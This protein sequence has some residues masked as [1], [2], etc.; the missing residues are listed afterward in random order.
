MRLVSNE[1]ENKS[2]LNLGLGEILGQPT[3]KSAET[4]HND[5]AQN[6]TAATSFSVDATT[7]PDNQSVDSQAESVDEYTALAQSKRWSELAAMA[8]KHNTLE[9][10]LWWAIAQ[11]ELAQMP[12]SIISAPLE[13]SLR[14]IA[15]LHTVP[16]KL[17]DLST[18]VAIKISQALIERGELN[19][20][21]ALLESGR[22]FSTRLDAKFR[23]SAAKELNQLAKLPAR[24]L[25]KQKIARKKY[26]E[27][28]VETI[29]V[30]TAIST[31]SLAVKVDE[32]RQIKRPSSAKVVLYGV[33]LISLLT[34]SSLYYFGAFRSLS[35]DPEGGTF[36]QALTSSDLPAP[37]LKLLPVQR[38]SSTSMLEAVLIEDEQRHGTEANN[39]QS[40]QQNRV[41]VE[42]QLV[43][44]DRPNLPT[45]QSI[46]A[47]PVAPQLP[48]SPVVREKID[49]SGP[50]EPREIREAESRPRNGENRSDRADE[51][52]EKPRDQRDSGSNFSGNTQRYRVLVRTEVHAIPSF[53][54][55]VL[56]RL[57][58]GDPVAVEER[59]G[60]WF[61]IR[62][63]NGK[64]GYIAA[65]DVEPE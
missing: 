16:Q 22:S 53:N 44:N 7:T 17:V 35:L 8:E 6:S 20:A 62:G 37:T 43:I 25:D 14:E 13:Q 18:D 58:R 59:E 54:S 51:L 63:Q 33:L 32:T 24:E 1:R 65:Q 64:S 31:T 28:F 49:T 38:S 21:T 45:N 2:T 39:S 12:L 10:R 55:S 60:L 3:E 46:A 48:Q 56:Q 57:N 5:V 42:D 30:Q 52:F 36:A 15:Q 4:E 11:S 47:T 29:P 40:N 9:S 34:L 23:S 26:L 27:E 61:R 50:I 41:N 19:L